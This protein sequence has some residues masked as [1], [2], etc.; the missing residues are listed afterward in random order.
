MLNTSLKLLLILIVSLFALAGPVA[1]QVS[2]EPSQSQLNEV[3]AALYQ[4]L[5]QKL[6]VDPNTAGGAYAI[7]A[8]MCYTIFTDG[9]ELSTTEF[10]AIHTAATKANLTGNASKVASMSMSLVIYYDK[11]KRAGD[12]AK[13]METRKAAGQYFM[14]IVKEVTPANAGP[15][16]PGAGV[17]TSTSI[18]SPVLG[19]WRSGSSG[20]LYDTGSGDF[21]R[22]TR[23]G[24]G[25][26]FNSDGTF[27]Y[28]I[29]SIGNDVMNG[30]FVCRGRYQAAG[31]RL[32]FSQVV[33]S[34]RDDS[35]PNRSYTN[36]PSP[37]K[38]GAYRF[39]FDGDGLVID[40]PSAPNSRTVNNTGQSGG[41][42]FFR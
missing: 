37:E 22:Y 7:S 10:Q 5:G 27:E 34:W 12:Q 2:G 30:A 11:V 20:K 3:G 35:Y 32:H 6:G 28:Y 38:D 15:V 8:A 23:S 33:E 36:R 21:S 29:V 31:D 4:S 42:T 14:Q 17:A 41:H 1:A 13:I 39:Y 24:E 18:A 26:Q 40:S 25:Y 19:A 9:K 16:P